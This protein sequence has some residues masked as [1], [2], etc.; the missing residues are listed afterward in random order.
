M[1]KKIEEFINTLK[2]KKY[3]DINDIFT[4]D[5]VFYNNYKCNLYLY[6]RIST[7]SQDFGRQILEA[8]EWLKSKNL[9]IPICNI[10]CDIY[11]GKKL[12]RDSYNAVRNKMLEKDYI[13]LPEV[14]RLG[15]N[16][17]E[18]KDEWYKLK[19]DNINILVMDHDLLCA[20]LPNEK[21]KK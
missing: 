14:S 16:W 7:E 9:T 3:D 11:T 4:S 15:R 1:I 6:F 20:T 2:E 21:E 18:V 13:L 17:D 8:Y 10:Y 12:N 19:Q 5:N